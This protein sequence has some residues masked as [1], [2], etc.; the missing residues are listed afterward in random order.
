M[1]FF[2][3]LQAPCSQLRLFPVAW[4]W[5]KETLMSG[6]SGHSRG[7]DAE[8][9][10]FLEGA[11]LRVFLPYLQ[12]TSQRNIAGFGWR[13]HGACFACQKNFL[14]V[15]VLREVLLGRQTSSHVQTA[16]L[17]QS[18]LGLV[19]F[20]ANSYL[21]CLKFLFKGVSNLSYALPPL[22]GFM[23][24]SVFYCLILA[25]SPRWNSNRSNLMGEQT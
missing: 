17:S 6:M 8:R 15:G 2:L 3:Q 20:K 11:H 21:F 9:L 18:L 5:W 22:L 14:W 1:A 10:D 4:R 13:A 24:Q 16:C 12:D 19:Y 25:G 23:I 7:K